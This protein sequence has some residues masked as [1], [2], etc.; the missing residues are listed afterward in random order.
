MKTDPRSK[1]R[2]RAQRSPT[3]S[4]VERAKQ[5]KEVGPEIVNEQT[6]EVRPVFQKDVGGC[7]TNNSHNDHTEDEGSHFNTVVP[8]TPEDDPDDN[9]DAV[10]VQQG[11]VVG[12]GSGLGQVEPHV[13]GAVNEVDATIN[14]G[15]L[16]GVELGRF[17]EKVQALVEEEGDANGPELSP[18]SAWAKKLRIVD[19]DRRRKEMKRAITTDHRNMIP[20]NEIDGEVTEI[21]VVFRSSDLVMFNLD[22]RQDHDHDSDHDRRNSTFAAKAA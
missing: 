7:E 10:E 21:Q 16:L 8:N 6:Y 2:L 22:N 19:H 11:N 12:L 9:H 3:T 4:L 17:K 20:A 5:P 15:T 1:K 18:L 13:N 14:A